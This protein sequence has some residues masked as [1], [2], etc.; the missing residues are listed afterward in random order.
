MYRI[1]GGGGGWCRLDGWCVG[2][3]PELDSLGNR[4]KGRYY[5]IETKVGSRKGR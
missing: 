5:V 3:F 4:V 2:S 1:E